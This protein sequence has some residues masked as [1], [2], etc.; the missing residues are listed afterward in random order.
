M[1]QPKQISFDEYLD[2]VFASPI[3]LDAC[4]NMLSVF[5]E[6]I[7]ACRDNPGRDLPDLAPSILDQ[8]AAVAIRARR[9]E[10]HFR[11]TAEK[12]GPEFKTTELGAVLWWAGMASHKAEAAGRAVLKK[13]NQNAWDDV[14]FEVH[15]MMYDTIAALSLLSVAE[16]M[17]ERMESLA[18]SAGERPN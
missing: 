7:D 15:A 2:S 10:S 17:I 16:R 11:D 3:W 13:I 14:F 9:K 8:V 4:V 18:G 1:T 12:R 6:D 5:L